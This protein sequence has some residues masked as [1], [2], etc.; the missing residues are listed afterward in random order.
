[1]VVRVHLSNKDLALLNC[2]QAKHIKSI[3]GLNYNV[4]SNPLSQA[5]GIESIADHMV[6]QSLEQL[7]ANILSTSA[8]R[9]F[10]LY[11]LKCD[12]LKVSK[13]TVGRVYKFY[14]VYSI[15]FTKYIL[16]KDYDVCTKQRINSPISNGTNGVI[17]TCNDNNRSIL[18]VHINTCS[19]HGMMQCCPVLILLYY[20][21]SF[22]GSNKFYLIL[23]YLILSL[24]CDMHC[25][26]LFV[27][28]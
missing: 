22:L 25:I 11:L 7:K 19:S 26:S 2:T 15:N 5:I 16:K 1:M 3:L 20:F 23:S 4:H 28:Y 18:N 24:S 21:I 9:A 6:L 14:D 27:D 8:S 10:Y 13:T 12:K 17:D